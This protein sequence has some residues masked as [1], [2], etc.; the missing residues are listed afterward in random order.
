MNPA[1]SGYDWGWAQVVDAVSA[2]GLF[3]LRVDFRRPQPSPE[4][5]LHWLSTAATAE[6]AG[7]GEEPGSILHPYRAEAGQRAVH[8]VAQSTLATDGLVPPQE[9]I[10]RRYVTTAAGLSALRRGEISAL[11]RVSPWELDAA[12][13][14]P[15]VSVE[16]YALPTVHCLAFNPLRP[17]TA[18]RRFRRA[19]AYGIDRA[20]ILQRSLLADRAV[21]GCQVITGPFPRAIRAGDKYGYAYDA[22]VEDYPRDPALAMVLAG[23]AIQQAST[24][25]QT[26]SGPSATLPPLELVHPPD[27]IARL[28]C[29]SLARQSAVL[30]I[31]LSLR[32]LPAGESPGDNYDLLYVELTLAEPLVSVGRLFGPGGA[33]NSSAAVTTACR[34]V[35]EASSWDEAIQRLHALHRIAHQEVAVLPLWQLVEHYAVHASLKGIGRRPFS[36]YQNVGQWQ[37]KASADGQP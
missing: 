10:E 27:E 32:E 20:V 13:K 31:P 24:E 34:R 36:L 25:E 4:A 28:A 23:L 22:A 14:L 9:I 35:Y 3:E 7:A 12:R 11:D 37:C 29:Q 1:N 33:G 6:L 17:R 8:F 19:L 16:A 2:P 30:G 5:W 15:A 18:D 21:A 26:R